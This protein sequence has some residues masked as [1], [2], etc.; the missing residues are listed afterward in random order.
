MGILLM[1]EWTKAES[2]L[3]G[4]SRVLSDRA[5]RLTASVM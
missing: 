2:S 3:S 5:P 4:I 1:T